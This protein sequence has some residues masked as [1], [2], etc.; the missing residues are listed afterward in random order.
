MVRT[1]IQLTKEQAEALKR[2]AAQK[3]VSVAELIRQGVEALIRTVGTVSPEERRERAIAIT[4]RFRSGLT[5]LSTKHDD[6]LKEA[7]KK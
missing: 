6:Y 5:D 3:H 7:Y 2:L 1:Q 4:G